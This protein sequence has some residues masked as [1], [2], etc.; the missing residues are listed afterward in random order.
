MTRSNH[1]GCLAQVLQWNAEGR[2]TPMCTARPG[3]MTVSPRH[4]E[5]KNHLFTVS[6]DLTDILE[7]D[8]KTRLVRVEP[9]VNIL[10]ILDYLLP[11]GWT[12]PVVPELDE[13]TVGGLVNGYGIL[14]CL[15]FPS[16]FL[17][18]LL[19]LILLLSPS[20]SSLLLL[21]LLL[22]P[23]AHILFVVCPE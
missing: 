12:L 11:R 21:L 8:E 6:I 23:F 5:Y 17:L 18:L 10:Q 19:L 14:F 16:F 1:V 4:C 7:I 3:W 20:S 2:R 13:L 9:S 15:L 22:P